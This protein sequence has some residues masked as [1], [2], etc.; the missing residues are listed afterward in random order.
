MWLHVNPA[1]QHMLG[2]E[3]EDI[4][5]DQLRDLLHPDDLPTLRT[6]WQQVLDAGNG[7]FICRIC[8][9]DGS[10]RC[11]ET[12]A[13][14]AEHGDQY[15]VVVASHDITEHKQAQAEWQRNNELFRVMVDS[16]KDYAIF[17]TDSA[18]HIATWNPGAQRLFG[19]T[20]DEIIG[21]NGS[22]IFTPEDRAAGADKQE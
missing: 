18:G 12:H 11:L 9:E 10:W 4:L 21:Q 16:V 5:G 2:Y 19:Y 13:T 1:C 6:N 8:H 22:L 3:P 20:K 17:A 15:Y 7:Q 14:H